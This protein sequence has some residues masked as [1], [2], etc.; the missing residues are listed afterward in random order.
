MEKIT[1]YGNLHIF[2]EWNGETLAKI[3][4]VLRTVQ[5]FEKQANL[6]NF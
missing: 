5:Q 3:F 4:Y 2:Q 1:L 6:K